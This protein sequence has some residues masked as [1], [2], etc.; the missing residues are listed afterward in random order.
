ML[1]FIVASPI[2][3]IYLPLHLFLAIQILLFPARLGRC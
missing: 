1:S 2:R 3:P